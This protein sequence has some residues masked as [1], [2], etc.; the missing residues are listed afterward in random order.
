MLAS[1]TLFRTLIKRSRNHLRSNALT[2]DL[3]L[4]FAS[5]L[6]EIRRHVGKCNVLLQERRGRTRRDVS[7]LGAG[8]VEYFVTVARDATIDHLE[9]NQNAVDAL[10]FLLEQ[11]RLA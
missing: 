5:D 6:R 9:S 2:A 8:I 10:F 4:H 11:R 7:N 3:Y 1:L